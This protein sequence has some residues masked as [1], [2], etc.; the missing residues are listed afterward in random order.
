MGPMRHVGSALLALLAVGF[1]VPSE[2]LRAAEADEASVPAVRVLGP[3][4]G[5]IRRWIRATGVVT[6]AERLVVAAETE[7]RLADIPVDLGDTVAAD[8]AVARLDSPDLV[9]AHERARAVLALRE[10]SLGRVSATARD[11]AALALAASRRDLAVARADLVLADRELAVRENLGRSGMV[12]GQELDTAR[13]GQEKARARVAYLEAEVRFHEGLLTSGAWERAVEQARAERDVAARDLASA[14]LA[15]ERLVVRARA[16]GV[17]AERLVEPG[18]TIRSGT[19]LVR[20][21]SL[22]RPVVD[23]FVDETSLVRIHAGQVVEV[24]LTETAPLQGTVAR[25]APE[26][27]SETGG[28]LV[29]VA[30]EPGASISSGRYAVCRILV[31]ERAGALLVPRAALADMGGRTVVFVVDNESVA[32]E[33]VVQVGLDEDDAV[34]I[35]SGLA[36]DARLVVEG[37]FGLD[38]GR[39]VR[40]VDEDAP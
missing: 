11:E 36:P 31:E 37:A 22:G 27:S 40:V 28:F 39:R 9:I 3:R 17:V 2:G 15:V 34:E 32:R 30:L 26:R 33:Q 16:P 24:V 18:T 6:P 35:L 13:A 7:G 5:T 20:L 23:C 10:A 1:L 4:R 14:A 19:A 38:D 8:T 12:P 25:V 29:R 21:V